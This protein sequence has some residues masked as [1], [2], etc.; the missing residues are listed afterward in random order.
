MRFQEFQVLSES[1]SRVVYHYT[2]IHPALKILKSGKFQLS[3]T[4]G[5]VEQQYAPKG[6]PYFLST[7]RTKTGGYHRD[8][9]RTYGVLFVLD[10]DWFNRHYKSGPVDYWQNRD[11]SQLHHRTHEAED[12][13]FS[14]EPTIPVDGVSAVHVFADPE[15]N[16]P[17]GNAVVRKL[18]IAAKS[19]EIPAYFYTDK[20][21]WL[22]MDTRKQG[23]VSMLKGQERT[24][25]Y[26]ST[27]PG[28]LVPWIELISA[29]DKSQLSKKADQIRYGL[30]RDY[31]KEESARGLANDLSNAR[32]PESGPDREHAI[33]LIDFMRKNNLN[34]VRELVNALA[35]KWHPKQ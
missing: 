20:N 13:V 32:K 18:L 15:D 1:L 30:M 19:Q 22:N 33:K 10:G 8:S 23:N 25:G 34:T 31:N 3:S 35:D 24:G 5:S 4:L 6:K 12:R 9:G 21:A 29:K 14:S 11:P 17:E 16:T 7:T 26:V 27:H 28:Y 2:P